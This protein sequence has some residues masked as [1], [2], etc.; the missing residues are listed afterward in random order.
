SGASGVSHL[1]AGPRVVPDPLG[2][3]PPAICPT[4]PHHARPVAPA[5]G[6]GPPL[7]L[8]GGSVL[9]PGVREGSGSTVSGGSGGGVPPPSGPHTRGGHNPHGGSSGAHRRGPT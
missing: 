8:P 7:R 9:V 4:R 3:H 1:V 2:F 6:G 5:V